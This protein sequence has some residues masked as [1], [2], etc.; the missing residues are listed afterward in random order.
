ML[1]W[2]AGLWLS[3]G[4]AIATAEVIIAGPIGALLMVRMDGQELIDHVQ[5][6]YLIVL[7]NWALRPTLAVLSFAAYRILLSPCMALLKG[8]FSV[9]YVGNQGGHIVG[10]LGTLGGVLLLSMLSWQMMLRLTA[11][12]ISIPDK[13]PTLLGFP[14]GGMADAEAHGGGTK[15]IVAMGGGVAGGAAR[16]AGS[17]SKIPSGGGGGGAPGLRPVGGGGAGP[18]HWTRASGGLEGLTGEQQQAAQSA[19]G[20]WAQEN[21]GPASKYGLSEYVDYAQ[22]REAARQ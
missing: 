4:W 2:I 19:Y 10:I 12:I 9:A 11:I 8:G 21:P 16:A 5:R 15:A 17:A 20:E 3:V 18:G 13:I 1:P 7:L 14:G 6:P 22:Q